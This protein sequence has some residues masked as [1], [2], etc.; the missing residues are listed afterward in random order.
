MLAR[1]LANVTHDGRFVAHLYS[2]QTTH[3]PEHLPTTTHVSKSYEN[4]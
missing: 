3:Y 4:D 2:A 1:S